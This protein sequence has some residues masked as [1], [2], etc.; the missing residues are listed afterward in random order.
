M[1]CGEL[2]KKIRA[3]LSPEE[4]SEKVI[5]ESA[6]NWF[7]NTFVEH[8]IKGMEKDSEGW[9]LLDKTL[10]FVIIDILN[11][12]RSKEETD[13]VLNT[14]ITE[15]KEMTGQCSDKYSGEIRTLY[16]LI[17]G[18]ILE[19]DNKPE[20]VFEEALAGQLTLLRTKAFA[21]IYKHFIKKYQI[22][23]ASMGVHVHD[24]LNWALEERG[25]FSQKNNAYTL[26]GDVYAVGVFHDS[27]LKAEF[28]RWSKHRADGNIELQ[29][30]ALIAL[31]QA[32][33]TLLEAET[34]NG[35][36]LLDIVYGV[37]SFVGI[38]NSLINDN[39]L[40]AAE[41][42]NEATREAIQKADSF[43]KAM[44]DYI[45]KA[46]SS[47]NNNVIKFFQDLLVKKLGATVSLA[48]IPNVNLFSGK[49][50]NE[51]CFDIIWLRIRESAN[52]Q[53]FS[54]E[55]F[56][57]VFQEFLGDY[58]P[59]EKL[60]DSILG[61]SFQDQINVRITCE[62]KAIKALQVIL[63]KQ[64][65]APVDLTNKPDILLDYP[66]E[67]G[68]HCL[69]NIWLRVNALAIKV[70]F[71]KDNFGGFLQNELNRL[72]KNR[73]LIPQI[74]DENY[75][76]LD[77]FSLSDTISLLEVMGIFSFGI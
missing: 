11:K 45:S 46:V 71:N 19:S 75:A 21:T 14:F 30:Q 42:D 77:S 35:K 57:R 26:E 20:D 16:R 38:V 15:F 18:A 4:D 48:N 9:T 28:D 27:G 13:Y 37:D 43:R 17:S 12:K 7:R 6:L 62:N 69:D 58:K 61:I 70:G 50:V 32:L 8:N 1:L 76:Y 54:K 68:E 55:A 67:L 63:E 59:V 33:I 3:H 60:Q 72:V 74:T 25:I 66:E 73:P 49:M 29:N 22:N 31:K 5:I 2:I 56:N 40:K 52:K 10:A 24:V 47:Q 39:L 51:D 53:N 44:R 23:E 64:L 65:G 34:L 41:K 36:G